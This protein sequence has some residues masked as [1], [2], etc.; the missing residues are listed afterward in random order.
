MKRLSTAGQVAAK[1]ERS[2]GGG[3]SGSSNADLPRHDAADNGTAKS[4]PPHYGGPALLLFPAHHVRLEDIADVALNNRRVELSSIAVEFM[5]QGRARLEAKLAAND[6]VYGVNTGFGGNSHC[7][8]PASQLDEHQQNLLTFLSAGTGDRLAFEYVRAAQLLTV[9][10]LVR[11]WSAV[12]PDVASSLVDYLNHGIVPHVPRYGSVGASGDLIPLSYIANALCGIGTVHYAGQTLPAAK[13]LELAGLEPLTVRAKEGIALVNGT[14]VMTAI[15]AITVLRFTTTLRA[16]L[17]ALAL[18]VEALQA[19]RDH[20]DERLHRAKDHPGQIM[21]AAALRAVL[22]DRTRVA[23]EAS[24]AAQ[25]ANASERVSHTSEG[26]QE[27]YSIRC[28]P[29]ILGPVVESLQAARLVLE[30]EAVS[31]NDNPLIDP[32]TGDAL[33]GGNFMGQ[34]VARTMDGLKIDIA[35]TANHLHSVMALLMDSRFSRGLPNSL[36]SE[37]GL[38]QGF[39]GVQLSQ[40]ALVA[41]LR[42]DSAPSCVH[43]LPTEQFNQDVVSLGLHAAL[44]AAE[45][46]TKLRD[47]VAMTLL[48]A[49][50]AIDLRASADHLAPGAAALQRSIRAVSKPLGKDRRL[51]ADIA[52]LSALI[53]DGKLPSPDLES[54]DTRGR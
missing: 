45:M 20:Y 3:P 24:D 2:R 28:A 19:S 4:N 40:T 29:Q 32:S 44:S 41:Q 13:A 37:V 33:N 27:V 52:S 30:R 34:H 50:Q 42:R 22:I 11:G 47:V 26:A 21:V 25:A 35:V 48:A 51:D 14:R 18:T 36:S 38:Y 7:I 5:K 1:H 43:S 39:K 9:L 10:A 46:E 15:A 54:E 8:I 49:A 17:G 23:Q 53:L 6:V 31:A 16:A 12:R